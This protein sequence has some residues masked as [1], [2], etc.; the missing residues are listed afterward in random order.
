M[1][2][3]E[4]PVNDLVLVENS[5]L[6]YRDITLEQLQLLM[7]FVKRYADVAAVN[8]RF[9]QRLFIGRFAPYDRVKILFKVFE[10][11][12]Q[13]ISGDKPLLNNL[14]LGIDHAIRLFFVFLKSAEY[15]CHDLIHS[16]TAKKLRH[17]FPLFLRHSLILYYNM[18]FL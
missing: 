7:R 9:E 8:Q 6:C 4:L 2:I 5:L 1:P 10:V 14:K 17:T 15:P 12:Y 11:V 3:L 16:L 13:F 18:P